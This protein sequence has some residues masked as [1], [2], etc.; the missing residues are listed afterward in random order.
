MDIKRMTVEEFRRLGFLQE[1][2]RQ[3]LH[4]L[5]LALEVIINDDGSESFGEV[6]DYRS[7]A[8]GIRFAEISEIDVAKGE[9]IERMQRAK[10]MERESLLGYNIQPLIK[11]FAGK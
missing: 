5:G 3:F 4:P 6:W 8:E 7:D 9:L 11:G 10:A 1:L 2:N